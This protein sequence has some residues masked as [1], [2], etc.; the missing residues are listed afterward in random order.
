MDLGVVFITGVV[1]G[2]LTCLAVQGGLL[3]TA[4][5]RQTQVQ[6]GKT[7]VTGTQVVQDLSPVLVFLTTKLIAYTLLGSVLG[8]LGSVAQ[9]TPLTQGIVQIT[10]GVFMLGTALNMLNVHPI[11]RYFA[12]QPPKAVRKFVRG[13][14]KSAEVFAPA[15]LGALT[16]LIP[17]GTTLS[18]MG[19]AV[20]TGSAWMGALV[21]F[22][23]VLGTAPT[24]LILGFIA[25]QGRGK[26]Q[27]LFAGVAAVLILVLGAVSIDTGLNVLGAPFAPS[28]VIASAFGRGEAVP[29]QIVD[30]VQEFTVRAA[31]GGYTPNYLSAQAG[32]PIRL[33][34]VTQDSLGCER[35]FTIPQLGIEQVLPATGEVVI[36][37]PAQSG[38]EIFFSCSMGM[39]T[40]IIRIEA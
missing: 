11:F 39:Y 40:G 35:A 29:A 26:L 17:C 4:M 22:T 33:R 38:G 24:F 16:V 36:D 25:T 12:L 28:R 23:F 15:L 9:I 34:M 2:G 37:L 31:N 5:T 6:Q 3:A 27:P 7:T 13:Q 1:S 10:V 8:A 18:M 21:L 32:M 14:S 20:N 19:E 30:G